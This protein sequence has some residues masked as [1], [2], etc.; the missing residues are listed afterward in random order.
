MKIQE[1]NQL[2]KVSNLTFI[3]A[4]FC[5]RNVTGQ[6]GTML[7]SD[8]KGNDTVDSHYRCT[9]GGEV[10]ESEWEPCYLR[11]KAKATA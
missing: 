10:A 4:F 5:G 6:I 9:K 1:L 7:S 11:T 8:G 2:A 3:Y